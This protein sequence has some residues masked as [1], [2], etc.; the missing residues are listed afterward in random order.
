MMSEYRDR[1]FDC[2]DQHCTGKIVAAICHGPQVLISVDRQRGTDIIRG[3]R[4][5]GYAATEDDLRDAGGEYVDLPLG[6]TGKVVTGRCP[7]DLPEFCFEGS[8]TIL[9]LR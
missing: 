8:E 2:Q 4:V 1:T 5:T 7:D 3:R 6:R 9:G